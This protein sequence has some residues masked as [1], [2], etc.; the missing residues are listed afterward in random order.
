M[1]NI[2]FICRCHESV[3][4][5]EQAALGTVFVCTHGGAKHGVSGCRR[6]YLSSRDLQAHIQYRHLREQSAQPQLTQ[7]PQQTAAVQLHQRQDYP[8]TVPVSSTLIGMT[9]IPPPQL[10]QSQQQQQV[11]VAGTRPPAMYQDSVQLGQSQ[12]QQMLPQVPPP[13]LSLPQTFTSPP[14]PVGQTGVA[15]TALRPPPPNQQQVVMQQPQQQNFS[16]RPPPQSGIESYHTMAGRPT[17]NLI[18]IPIQE[19]RGGY[20][21]NPQALS[22]SQPP[23]NYPPPI[24][25]P[26]R[27]FPQVS[28]ATGNTGP[29]PPRPG[30]L[31]PRQGGPPPPP[32]STHGPGGMPPRFPSGQTPPYT[33]QPQS[34]PGVPWQGP[35]GP[36]PRGPPPPC[37]PGVGPPRY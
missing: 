32:V 3:V 13:T 18:T 4:R 35:N 26:P 17:G 22:L 25:V 12:Q 24:N 23:P 1:T 11:V 10:G 31:P 19:E 9:T 5:V 8:G 37:G 30:H 33:G 21:A 34:A 14:P 6:T 27:G 7:Q 16:Q 15:N 20:S 2:L 36:P 28:Y 29:P